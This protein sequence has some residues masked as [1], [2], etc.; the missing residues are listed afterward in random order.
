MFLFVFLF[1]LINITTGS[2]ESQFV[3]A[4]IALLVLLHRVVQARLFIFVLLWP[5]ALAVVG[6]FAASEWTPRNA[7][8]DEA[9]LNASGALLFVGSLMCTAIVAFV[10]FSAPAS[11]QPANNAGDVEKANAGAGEQ[12]NNAQWIGRVGVFGRP[13]FDEAMLHLFGAIS[14][15]MIS[16][17]SGTIGLVFFILVCVLAAAVH[18]V[19]ARV[20]RS[21]AR[22]VIGMFCL[23]VIFINR[24]VFV[25]YFVFLISFGDL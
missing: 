25:L 21:Y 8:E 20:R 13:W 19:L 10:S 15:T 9:M 23:M 5:I 2:E 16:S 18:F 12:A 22:F 4:F 3:T 11:A 1:P 24:I 6:A 7:N 17:A 14:F